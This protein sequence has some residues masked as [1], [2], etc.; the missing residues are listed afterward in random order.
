M[1]MAC[2]PVYLPAS[3]WDKGILSTMQVLHHI[4]HYVLVSYIVKL[5]SGRLAVPGSSGHEKGAQRPACFLMAM[6]APCCHCVWRDKTHHARTQ[7]IM[8]WKEVEIM[9]L[10]LLLL[11]LLI[12]LLLLF[13]LQ[14]V[15]QHSANGHQ[16]CC[17]I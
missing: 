5:A 10:L 12:S 16:K 11:L 6:Y 4:L 15:R 7:L 9:A 2:G 17:H 13:M 14:I 3:N 1:R 8:S